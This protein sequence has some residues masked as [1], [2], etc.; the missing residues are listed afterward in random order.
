MCTA[1]G[2]KQACPP[3]VPIAEL[4]KRAGIKFSGMNGCVQPSGE[5]SAAVLPT[6]GLIR[7]VI[8]VIS[9]LPS[10]LFDKNVKDRPCGLLC[11][12]GAAGML[13]CDV[14]GLPPVP[15]VLAEPIG[16]EAAKRDAELSAEIKKAKKAAQR[17]GMDVE[18]A[19]A[20]V[21]RRSVKLPLP[22]TQEIAKVWRQI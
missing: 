1:D 12:Y 16:K 15:W 22:T 19:A 4:E 18:R 21:A 13:I 20:D 11:K 8:N 17:K 7:D 6:Y 3:E 10:V 5:G 2:P 9:G 14:L